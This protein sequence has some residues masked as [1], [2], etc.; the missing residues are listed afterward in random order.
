[1]DGKFIIDNLL[2]QNE[3]D[4]LVFKQQTTEEELAPFVTSMLNGRGGDIVLG[5]DK[6]KKVVGI[7]GVE[8]QSIS[9]ILKTRIRPFAPIE[10]N[11]IDYEGKEVVLISVWEG[12][13]KPYHFDGKIYKK[14]GEA[15][16]IASNENLGEMLAERKK[17]EFNWERLPVLG[18]EIEDLDL[19]EVRKTMEEY[20]RSGNERIY[21]EE[22]FLMRNGLLKDGNLTNACIVLYAKHPAQFIAQARI[23]LSKYATDSPADLVD[24]HVF[25]DNLFKNID[26]LFQFLDMNYSKSVKING[27]LRNERWNYPRVA[28]REAIL[29]AIVHRDYNS[30]NG[31]MQVKLYPNR[32]EVV[33]YGI[34]PSIASAVRN[35]SLVFSELRNP[36][37][38]HQCYYR[39]LIE[40]MGTGLAR[41]IQV[42]MAN[43]FDVPRFEINEQVVIVTFPNVSLQTA[44]D[45][46]P[47]TTDMKS[48]FEGVIEGMNEGIS[49]DL[50]EKLALILCIL[51]EQPGLRT[52]ML[53]EKTNIPVKSLERYVKQLKDAGLIKFLGASKTGGY[54]LSD[55][56]QKE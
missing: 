23:K 11:Q 38:A 7:H 44:N 29:N 27:L 35:G 41:M 37:I 16:V 50:K 19:D 12:A 26:S 15:Y 52:T 56:I 48:Y 47:Q 21:D 51:K 43:G 54:F 28:V 46:K 40:M 9:N 53:G 42:C 39:K 34:L 55:S 8:T 2:Q 22:L 36:D 20:A 3:S 1:M 18:A 4:R 13:Q 33:S 6:N 17:S 14:V 10:V 25:E 49:K 5:I 45:K 32:M 31:F 30:I 24:V